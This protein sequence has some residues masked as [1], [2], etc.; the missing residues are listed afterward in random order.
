MA[1]LFEEL[2]ALFFP[3]ICICC[4]KNL[5]DHEELVCLMC[6]YSL[7]KTNFHLIE[8][9]PVSR[10]FWGRAW[11]ENAAACYYFTKGGR[12]Q[13]MIHHLKYKNI[14]EIGVFL[15][16]KYGND[17]KNSETFNKIEA[18]IPVP[19]HPKRKRKRGYNQSEVFA[20]GLSESMGIP[21]ETS[22]LRRSV[23]S[24]TQTKKSKFSRWENVESIFIIKTP[25]KLE[26]K[27]VLLVDDVITTGATLEACI[28]S[29]QTIP[30][31]K[32]SIASIAAVV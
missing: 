20:D 11:I 4:G 2:Y 18:I 13:H 16:K 27:H 5:F 14:P 12:I 7:P 32:V 10:L 17:L 29:L 30:G 22:V 23:A 9:N 28:H 31:V 3:R 25:E 26:N 8:D 6:I 1:N 24:Q 19:L 15:G 21:V